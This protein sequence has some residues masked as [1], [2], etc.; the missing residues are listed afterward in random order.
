MCQGGG[1]RGRGRENYSSPKHTKGS[2]AHFTLVTNEY[3][4]AQNMHC[5]CMLE[6]G[7]EKGRKE[8]K[9]KSLRK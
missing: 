8:R 5:K 3:T 4:H 7:R 6:R 9:I 1:K 2:S